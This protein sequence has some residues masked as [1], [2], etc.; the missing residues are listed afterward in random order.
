M[1]LIPKHNFDRLGKPTPPQKFHLLKYLQYRE[2][3]V[4]SRPESTKAVNYSRISSERRAESTLFSSATLWHALDIRTGLEQC[5][6][7]R[8]KP[9]G[10]IELIFLVWREISGSMSRTAR[11]IPKLSFDQKQKLWALEN[12]KDHSVSR[13]KFQML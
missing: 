11:K 3:L 10:L 1:S 4:R 5:F 7:H 9:K 13:K 2:F 6:E 8:S 12:P